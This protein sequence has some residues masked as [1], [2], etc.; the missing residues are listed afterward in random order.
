MQLMV[1]VNN[2]HASD[3]TPSATYTQ[4]AGEE[5]AEIG[6]EVKASAASVTYEQEGFQFY[7]DDNNESSAT[8]VGSQD[9]NMTAPTGENRRLRIL[10]NNTGDAPGTAYRLEYRRVGAGSWKVV[11]PP[12]VT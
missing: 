9:A 5:W 1:Q 12:P 8:P 10:L 11:G 2:P 3:L 6:I 4:T 7:L